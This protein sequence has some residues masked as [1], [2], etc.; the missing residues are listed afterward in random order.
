MKV[1]TNLYIADVCV[2][3]LVSSLLVNSTSICHLQIGI[4][5]YQFCTYM[6]SHI[7]FTFK[8]GLAVRIC[9][10]HRHLEENLNQYD[11]FS[12]TR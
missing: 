2:F 3:D 9:H 5:R 10:C 6:S 11:R 8:I 7:I 1:R 12:L 4:N